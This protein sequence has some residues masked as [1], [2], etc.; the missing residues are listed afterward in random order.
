MCSAHLFVLGLLPPVTKLALRCT[1]NPNETSTLPDT[2]VT[3]K[4]YVLLY[5]IRPSFADSFQ[6]HLP[7]PPN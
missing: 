4:Q 2:F 5:N 3:V 6:L 1:L 7:T